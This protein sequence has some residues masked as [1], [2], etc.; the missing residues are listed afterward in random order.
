MPKDEHILAAQDK[1]HRE[2]A[3]LDP[4]ADLVQAPAER[5]A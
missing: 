2:N 5:P 3:R 1:Y 4:Y